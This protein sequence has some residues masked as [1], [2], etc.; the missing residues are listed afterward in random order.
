MVGVKFSPPL[1]RA[2]LI[3]RYKR[4]LADVRLEDGREITIHCPNTGSMKNCGQ[5]G[6][7]VFFS[8]SDNPKR[9]YA[10][11]WE[12]CR[13]H[14]G[15]YIGI[16]SAAAN[17]LV[18]A[19]IMAG[20]VTELQGYRE[21]GSEYSYGSEASRVDLF[22]SDHATRTNCCVEVKSVTL[23]EPPLRE[24][25]GYFP[26]AVSERGSK[27][28]RELGRVAR[29]GGRAVLFF[30]VQH[31]G[32]RSVA[33]ADHIDPVYGETLRAAIAEGM[34]VI[35]YKARLSPSGVKIAKPVPVVID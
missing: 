25:R 16:N 6:D 10:H 33:P 2:E 15:H 22:L 32:I 30:C 31:S 35:A 18:K 3:R 27:H 34:E 4:F 26:D 5:P 19:A 11:T 24:G 1:Q 9:K 14:R 28:L 17:E 7:E 21:I 29:D 23:L 13:T 8:T 20:T 12:L